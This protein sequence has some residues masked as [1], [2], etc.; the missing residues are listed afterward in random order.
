MVTLLNEYFW[1][2]KKKLG[3]SQVSEK[4]DSHLLYEE[5]DSTKI[6]ES[7]S[8]EKVIFHGK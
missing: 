3:L 6:R 5:S 7:D 8:L 4:S 1:N 2:K